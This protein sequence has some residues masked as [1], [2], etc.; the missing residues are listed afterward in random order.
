MW[1]CY[2]LSRRPWHKLFW[3]HLILKWPP[4]K[5]LVPPRWVSR[6]VSRGKFFYTNE[7]VPLKQR[8]KPWD[9]PILQFFSLKRY[10]GRFQWGS[11]LKTALE[12][13]GGDNLL[14]CSCSWL[15]F[16]NSQPGTSASLCTVNAFSWAGHDRPVHSQTD[17]MVFSLNLRL[18]QGPLAKGRCTGGKSGTEHQFHHFHEKS[19][20]LGWSSL[21]IYATLS[22]SVVF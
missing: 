11:W 12:S 4:I 2:W 7:F 16:L 21:M 13:R 17:R 18:A 9:G 5:F 22:T 19:F 15:Q 20:F 10:L 1:E 6:W 8:W 3:C 14:A